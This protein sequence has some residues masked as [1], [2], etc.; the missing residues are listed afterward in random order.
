MAQALMAQALMAQVSERANLRHLR[1]FEAVA[2]LGSVSGASRE[3]RLSQPAV[4]QAIAKLEARIGAALF[5]RHQ[6]GCHLT[7]YGR[8]YLARTDRM[9]AEMEQGLVAPFV[10]PPFA[11]DKSL[12]TILA[13]ITATHV[14]ALMAVAEHRSI[15][16]AALN[17]GISASSLARAARDLEGVLRRTLFHPGL[18]GLM[19]T[20]PAIELAR[21]FGLACRE[22]TY[23][24]EEIATLKG[25]STSRVV[26]GTLPLFP[27][28]LIARSVDELL[29][30]YPGTQVLVV[31]GAYLSLL[32]DL[33]A[34]KIDFLVSVLRRP[35]WA[36][37]VHE[38]ALFR[39][40]YAIVARR[41]HPLSLRRKITLQDL[42]A[43]EWVL[44][45][46]GTPRR[47]AFERMFADVSPKPRA[48]IETRSME[49]QRGILATSDR[50][51]IVTRRESLLEE[52]FGALAALPF[53]PPVSRQADGVATRANWKPTTVQFAFLDLLRR[54][55]RVKLPHTCVEPHG[56]TT[57]PSL[58]ATSAVGRPERGRSH[59]LPRSRSGVRSKPPAARNGRVARQ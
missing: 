35:D 25:M 42:A 19:P 59:G 6:S 47:A 51:S 44:P 46:P 24:N 36:K 4:T 37:D 21:R 54:S 53:V 18:Q 34:G 55:A 41:G 10:G 40:P 39:D 50:V 28:D 5:E 57:R 48:S 31:E 27:A 17:L 49:F 15:E 56:Q 22:L 33:R 9:F 52:R 12:K 58:P 23:A 43:F 8:T 16:T 2:R 38:E 26:I 45:Q 13:K 1:V 30:I 20:E 32:A 11:D 14:R 3:A 7:E 29:R